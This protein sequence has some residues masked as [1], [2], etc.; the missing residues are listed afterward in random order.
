MLTKKVR[1]RLLT[2]LLILSDVRGSSTRW[3]FPRLLLGIVPAHG[4]DSEAR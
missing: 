3:F 1:A 4:K 2:G